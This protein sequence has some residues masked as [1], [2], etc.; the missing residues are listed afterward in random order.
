MDNVFSEYK[1]VSKAI[2][3]LS[4]NAE[5]IQKIPDYMSVTTREMQPIID[6]SKQLEAMQA[7]FKNIGIVQQNIQNITR[8]YDFSVLNRV[9]ES[10]MINF[11]Q[12]NMVGETRLSEQIKFLVE[13]NKPFTDYF[14][15]LQTSLSF[16]DSLDLVRKQIPVLF[17]YERNFSWIYQRLYSEIL[18]DTFSP[19]LDEDCDLAWKNEKSIIYSSSIKDI[20]GLPKLF[21]NISRQDVQELLE[22]L[23]TQPYTALENGIA[24]TILRE[25]K[26]SLA[27]NLI[28]IHTGSTFLHGR[29]HL[30]GKITFT[31]DEMMKAPSYCVHTERFNPSENPAYYL[32]DSIETIQKELKPTSEE[33]DEQELQYIQITTKRPLYVLDIRDKECPV[34]EFCKYPLTNSSPRPKEYLIPN[35]IAQCC[36]QLRETDDI[37]IDGI[38]YKSTIN[39]NGQ[40]LVL[41]RANSDYFRITKRDVIPFM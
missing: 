24:K 1:W 35:F 15:S 12:L 3:S 25:M 37:Q 30:K 8:V 29:K 7:P 39:P 21:E 18:D 38:L 26:R 9:L 27:K 4:A 13:F 34:F 22:V 32:G 10:T 20:Y 28:E 16:I 19:E 11:H 5:M 36:T 2:E 40:C 33:K 41:F 31:D 6:Y 23:K 17:N 14:S